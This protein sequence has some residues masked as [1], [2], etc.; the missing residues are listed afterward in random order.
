MH[1]NW[2]MLALA[3]AMMLMS[4]PASAAE[5]I[6]NGGFETPATTTAPGSHGSYAYPEG[7]IGGWTFHSAGLIDAVAATPWF[8]GNPPQGYQGSQYGFV[9]AIGTLSQTFTADA[10]GALSLSWLDAGRPFFGGYDGDQTYEVWLDN[11]LLGTFSTFSGQQ[12]TARNVSG[13]NVVAGQSYTL[14]FKGLSQTD[15]TA[16]VDAVSA[17]VAAAVPEPAAWAMMVGGFALIGLR[18]RRQVARVSS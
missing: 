9:Q 1:M 12:F 5:L 4:F 3:S 10:S 8:G 16:F 14:K 18:T 2:K 17:N 6:S 15:N 11:G 13:G 7:T